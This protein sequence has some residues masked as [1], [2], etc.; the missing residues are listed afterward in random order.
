[1]TEDKDCNYIFDTR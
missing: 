1:M